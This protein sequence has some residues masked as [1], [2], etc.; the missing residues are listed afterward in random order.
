MTRKLL[1][2]AL[3]VALVAAA[4]GAGAA[5]PA[6]QEDSTAVDAEIAIQQPSYVESSVDTP[7]ENG[8]TVYVASG[9]RLLIAPQNFDADAV[10]NY[11]IDTDAGRL[12][13]DEDLGLYRFDPQGETGTF[14]M[15]WVANVETGVD[16]NGSAT[17]QQ[18]RYETRV[19]IAGQ[20]QMEHLTPA[21]ADRRQNM[22]DLGEYVNATVGDLQERGLLF[23]PEDGSD[24]EVVDAMASRAISTGDPAAA[25]TG[26]ATQFVLL[27]FLSLGGAV[28]GGVMLA[29][30]V[31]YM[32]RYY[33]QKRD[34]ESVEAVEGEIDV[35]EL[36]VEE[37][38]RMQALANQTPADIFEDEHVA[39]AMRDVFGETLLDAWMRLQSLILPEAV[40]RDR[41]QAMG[42]SGWAAAPD[43]DGG[44]DLVEGD[45][46]EGDDDLES[47]TPP[48]E[49]VVAGVDWDAS[50]LRNF[51][52]VDADV[53]PGDFESDPETLTLTELT[54][55]LDVQM[56]NFENEEEF[57][58]YFYD[59]IDH[60]RESDFTDHQGRPDD[61]R[62][63]INCFLKAAGLLGDRHHWP[64]ADFWADASEYA[65]TKYDRADQV[66]QYVDDVQNGVA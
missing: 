53:D 47:L 22:A 31:Y 54:E 2:A 23:F 34:I 59:L 13:V 63:A 4:A 7:T 29:V 61:L 48:A 38:E 64:V 51:D 3:A 50:A 37:R 58:A 32:Y 40:V 15:F 65:L 52:L 36:D 21:E 16:A 55:S 33:K 24:R 49:E 26:N 5:A 1:F 60:I 11:G 9:E 18:Q 39:A 41:L 19:R 17:V 42:H 30:L 57:G 8:S 28:V 35:R 12:S 56:R 10:V 44:F 46:A 66:S 14:R 20:S 25:L 27:M 6:I 43:G 62:V 45:P